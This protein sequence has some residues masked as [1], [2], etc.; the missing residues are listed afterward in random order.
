MTEQKDHYLTCHVCGY[1]S[2]QLVWKHGSWKVIGYE[3]ERCG[4][5]RCYYDPSAL[6][7]DKEDAKKWLRDTKH[8]I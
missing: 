3:C 2:M 4:V 5:R 6:A 1:Q 8:Y 7:A